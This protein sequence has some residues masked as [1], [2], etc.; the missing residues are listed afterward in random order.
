MSKDP[1]VRTDREI[2]ETEQECEDAIARGD[3][4]RAARLG[5]RVRALTVRGRGEKPISRKG[6]LIKL[7]EV[8]SIAKADA[9]WPAG[10][11]AGPLA[12]VANRIERGQF[13][14]R[15]VAILEG[16]TG[17]AAALDSEI[18]SSTAA[19]LA[20]VIAW[21]KRKRQPSRT[22]VRNVELRSGT[23]G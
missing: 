7:R 8:V 10:R 21:C 6:A 12:G 3:R 11:L 22:D 13:N 17:F 14:G 4:R 2:R 5:E 1:V 19:A 20:G 15:D 23:A 18:G 16:S 9:G